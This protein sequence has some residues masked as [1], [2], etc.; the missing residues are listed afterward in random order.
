MPFIFDNQFLVFT[1]NKV[2]AILAG[3][4]E[5]SVDETSFKIG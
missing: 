5:R 4:L 2:F 3:K 1:Q